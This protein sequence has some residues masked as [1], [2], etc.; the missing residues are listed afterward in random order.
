MKESVTAYLEADHRELDLMLERVERT[1]ARSAFAE[2][3]AE[4]AEFRARLTLHMDREER[5]LFPRYE[6][7]TRFPQGPTR[8][9]RAEHVE[10][11]RLMEEISEA[12]AA[13]RVGLFERC[14]A[15]LKG[16]LALHN[17]KEERILYP[18]ADAMLGPRG[19]AA[20]VE[21][22]EA[23]RRGERT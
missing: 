5:V 14:A 4:F 3:L 19:A 21:Q 7:E 23:I 18:E 10:L 9:M 6:H 16:T 1:A 2:A 17:E 11:H 13:R 12:L 20:L 22:M 8:A 15:E